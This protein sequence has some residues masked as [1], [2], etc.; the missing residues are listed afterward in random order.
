MEKIAENISAYT[1]GTSEVAA[2]PI[3]LNELQALKISVGFTTEDECFLRRSP[4]GP[5]PTWTSR[6][7]RSNGNARRISS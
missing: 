6:K 1:Y 4:F 7:Q 5:R 2:S 3:S